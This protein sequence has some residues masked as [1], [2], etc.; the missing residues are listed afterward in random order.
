MRFLYVRPEVCPRGILFPESGFLQIPSRDGH[1][2]LRLCP[3]HYRADS[4]LPPV[5]NVR[6]RAHQKS[7]LSALVFQRLT[8]CFP[9]C[10]FQ[11]CCCR[12][13]FYLPWKQSERFQSSVLPD[14]SI[15]SSRR[16]CVPK[17]STQQKKENCRRHRLEVYYL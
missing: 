16:C 2:C 11:C 1:L 3:S 15:A 7:R 9:I 5:R 6:R 13:F 8:A 10:L 4:G 14:P 12:L 17:Q